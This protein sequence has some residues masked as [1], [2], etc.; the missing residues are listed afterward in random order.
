MSLMV[1]ACVYSQCCNFF[2]YSN[3]RQSK[4]K[5]CSKKCKG[6]HEYANLTKDQIERRRKQQAQNRRQRWAGLTDEEKSDV[7]KYYRERWGNLPIEERRIVMQKNA[8]NADKEK[9]KRRVRKWKRSSYANNLDYRLTHVLRARLRHALRG[10]AKAS[11]AKRLVGCTISELRAHLEQQFKDGMTWENY[12]DWHIDHIK[13][14]AAF[15][16][17]DPK[18]QRECFHYTNLQPLWAVDN[19]RKG[20]SY[21]PSQ[22]KI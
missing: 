12:G 7:Y 2:S 10:V 18:Q 21:E 16:L 8:E 5:Y 3:W 14:C 17:T 20:A 1:R 9:R 22:P 13:P 6:S 4:K 15:N 19:F 11:S